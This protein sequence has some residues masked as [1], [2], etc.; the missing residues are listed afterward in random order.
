MQN[1]NMRVMLENA[2]SGPNSRQ[3]SGEGRRMVGGV[4]E[5]TPT[6]GGAAAGGVPP[7]PGTTL[8]QFRLNE[9][10]EEERAN[11][12]VEELARKLQLARHAYAKIREAEKQIDLEGRLFEKY[13]LGPA[14]H[15]DLQNRAKFEKLSC[16]E[17]SP[18]KMGE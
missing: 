1:E 9:L 8:R 12:R 3:G 17:E 15:A 4:P 14:K 2:V 18:S 11:P 7:T 13:S 6:M 16:A 10:A 5:V